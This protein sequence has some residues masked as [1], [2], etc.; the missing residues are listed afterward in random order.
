MQS[1]QIWSF[2]ALV[3]MQTLTVRCTEINMGS[4]AVARSSLEPTRSADTYTVLLNRLLSD[5]SLVTC[6]LQRHGRDVLGN[7]VSHTN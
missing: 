2:R 4:V 5:Y 3:T 6:A 7:V 1:Q